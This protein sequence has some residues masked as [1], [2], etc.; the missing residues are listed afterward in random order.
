[1][2]LRDRLFFKSIYKVKHLIMCLL[3]AGMHV[4]MP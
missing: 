2:K 4:N 1:M 3:V